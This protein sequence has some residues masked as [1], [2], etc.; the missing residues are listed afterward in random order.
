[1]DENQQTDSEN[2]NR[3]DNFDYDKELLEELEELDELDEELERMF[4]EDEEEESL[5]ETS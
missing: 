2:R 3:D 4:K 1:M 5:Y